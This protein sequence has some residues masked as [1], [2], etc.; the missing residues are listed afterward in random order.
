MIFFRASLLSYL[1]NFEPDEDPA[2]LEKSPLLAAK[3]LEGIFLLGQPEL[4]LG[5]ENEFPNAICA[6]IISRAVTYKTAPARRFAWCCFHFAF[7]PY[8]TALI[9]SEKSFCWSSSYCLLL[10]LAV[11]AIASTVTC[12]VSGANAALYRTSAAR[13]DAVPSRA[14]I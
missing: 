9:A 3:L 13:A 4:L 12:S 14:C 1:P 8:Y 6:N 2:P 5:F 11:F 10:L 7:E